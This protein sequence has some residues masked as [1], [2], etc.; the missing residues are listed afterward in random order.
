M[1]PSRTEE[2]QQKSLILLLNTGNP[3]SS[4]KKDVAKFLREFLMDKHVISIPKLFRYILVKGIIIPCRK[5]KSAKRYQRLEHI[6]HNT[7]PLSHYMQELAQRLQEKIGRPVLAIPRYGLGKADNLKERILTL[8]AGEEPSSITVVALFPQFTGSSAYAALNYIIPLLKTLFPKTELRQTPPYYNHPQ[9]ISA[10][11][12]S[13]QPLSSNGHYVFSFHSIPLSHRKKDAQVQKVSY[14][15]Q[16]QTTYKLLTERLG[17]VPERCSMAFQSKMGHHQWESPYTEKL[18]FDLIANGERSFVLIAPGFSC[19]CL[20]T[21]DDLNYVLRGR[22][23]SAGARAIR[24]VP[25]LNSS[26]YAVNFLEQLISETEG[27]NK[28]ESGVYIA[29][30]C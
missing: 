17:L 10:L 29:E 5:K 2:S 14:V 23:M 20:E 3:K 26:V 28:K 11:T 6:C 30:Q 25:A 21:I 27:T 15:E 24:Y 4:K 12:Q 9:Y 18:V 22:M 8:T 19:D 7:M 13:I 1:E 16:C